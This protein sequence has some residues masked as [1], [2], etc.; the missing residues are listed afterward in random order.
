M[1]VL[2]TVVIIE[3]LTGRGEHGLD[4]FPSPLRAIRYH[5][6]PGCV[7][8]NHA[9]FFDVLERLPELPRGL[10]LMPAPKM[11]DPVVS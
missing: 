1:E 3:P 4:V 2:S 8:W 7:F 11:H 6:E 5:T 10:H 9:R